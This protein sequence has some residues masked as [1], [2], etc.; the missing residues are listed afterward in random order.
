MV[1][2]ALDLDRR[3]AA[4]DLDGSLA[5]CQERGAVHGVEVGVH[6]GRGDV[7]D[8]REQH[9]VAGIASRVAV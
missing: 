8:Q 3:A 5:G 2:A 9:L 1:E 7:S 4:E 6:H